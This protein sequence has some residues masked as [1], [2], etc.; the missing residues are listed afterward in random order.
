[1]SFPK[2]QQ[3]LKEPLEWL[4]RV[5]DAVNRCIDG[6]TNNTGSVTLTASATSTTVTLAAGRLGPDTVIL[7]TP[8]TANAASA[9]SEM[10][11]S[12]DPDNNQFTIM[13]SSTV[14]VDKTFDYV[15]VG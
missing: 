4:R 6:K 8:T 2:V 5:T 7:F 13:H 14:D 11:Y 9:L 15:V 1:M 3:G 12:T 10:Y